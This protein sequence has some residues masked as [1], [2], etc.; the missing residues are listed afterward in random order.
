MFASSLPLSTSSPPIDEVKVNEDAYLPHQMNVVLYGWI[1]QK[2]TLSI[3]HVKKI[4]NPQKPT[5]I[6]GWIIKRKNHKEEIAILKVANYPLSKQDKYNYNNSSLN[7]DDA[8]NA[9]VQKTKDCQP[10]I[11]CTKIMVPICEI[12]R[13]H[14]RL[15]V[16]DTINNSAVFY[17]SKSTIYSS[18][19][20]FCSST[21]SVYLSLLDSEA[22]SISKT[23]AD[24]YYYIQNTCQKYFPEI[25]ISYVYFGHQGMINHVDCG[26]YTLE[27][28][29]NHI[30]KI[31]LLSIP[32]IDLR[33]LRKEHDAVFKK[34]RNAYEKKPVKSPS[35]EEKNLSHS[36]LSSG[37][38]PDEPVVIAN[39]IVLTVE[40]RRSFFGLIKTRE[41]RETIVTVT[42]QSATDHIDEDDRNQ[43]E[44]GF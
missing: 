22:Q 5:D 38:A 41:V 17:E 21:V 15:L 1:E 9:Y 39:K 19:A 20:D 44:C 18:V 40:D 26:P 37:D 27:Y 12:G 24:N 2:N 34:Y 29:R 16:I 25:K 32:Q 13:N 35:D 30:L 11:P 4:F 33:E 36:L 6:V 10:E 14:F 8:L 23:F 31:D 28:M 42:P 3:E 7:L 43:Y